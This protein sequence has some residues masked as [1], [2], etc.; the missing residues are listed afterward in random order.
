MYWTQNNW[1]DPSSRK[2]SL[3]SHICTDHCEDFSTSL[4]TSGLAFEEFVY[5]SSLSSRFLD[6]GN[7][8]LLISVSIPPDSHLCPWRL[9]CI[10]YILGQKWQIGFVCS[11]SPN[12]LIIA[13]W[14]TMLRMVLR[15]SAGL[16]KNN[17]TINSIFHTHGKESSTYTMPCIGN[18]TLV[19]LTL[20]NN[21]LTNAL[22]HL[23]M[24][25]M[26]KKQR[27][28]HI[29]MVYSRLC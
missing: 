8:A 21:L 4:S 27:H 1:R 26:F 3:R 5:A 22:I 14:S 11:I 16:V 29:T 18:Y 17:A 10:L 6:L 24:R 15:L 25:S 12:H 7:Y 23:V 20:S 13:S 9:T 28:S 2:S 19:T